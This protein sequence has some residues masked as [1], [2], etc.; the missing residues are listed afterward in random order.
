MTN[1]RFEGLNVDAFAADLVALVNRHAVVLSSDQ[2]IDVLKCALDDAYE[3]A[4]E[5]LRPSAAGALLK[6]L[7]PFANLGVSSGPDDEYDGQSYRLTRGSIR[8]ARNACN[9][10]MAG[11]GGDG[12]S[13][14]DAVKAGA[15]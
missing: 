7:L 4:C 14:L 9:S 12:G 1:E 11:L 2:I 3:Q 15:K 13:V 6:A 10:A 5:P 8:A